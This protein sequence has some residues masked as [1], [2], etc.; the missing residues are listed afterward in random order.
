MNLIITTYYSTSGALLSIPIFPT[1]ENGLCK[2]AGHILNESNYYPFEENYTFSLD[3]PLTFFDYNTKSQNFYMIHNL[4]EFHF[5]LTISVDK[6]VY[7]NT[8]VKNV[9]RNN[10]NDTNTI[11][12]WYPMNDILPDNFVY[13]NKYIIF[14]P[15]ST[16][17]TK[18]LN[19]DP[20]CSKKYGALTELIAQYQVEYIDE[21]K[22]DEDI[23]SINLTFS[24][25]TVNPM[26][27]VEPPEMYILSCKKQSRVAKIIITTIA[28]ILSVGMMVFILIARRI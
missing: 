27:Y 2:Y 25:L 24:N 16:V 18:N 12:E 28:F 10:V 3:F 1:C 21:V 13:R 4:W 23:Q 7:R 14:C 5:S 6:N 17:I 9:T 11:I 22:L 20:Q 19:I 26:D 15:Y 8:I